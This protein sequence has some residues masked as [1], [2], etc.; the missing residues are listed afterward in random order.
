MWNLVL[1]VWLPITAGSGVC[2]FYN[3]TFSHTQQDVLTSVMS[4]I[5]YIYPLVEA[6]ILTTMYDLC[7][8]LCIFVLVCQISTK[9]SFIFSGS[10]IVQNA[11]RK[12]VCSSLFIQLD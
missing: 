7:I 12:V 4:D 11:N 1:K 10:P 3:T 6:A 5:N 8:A 9:A 2:C